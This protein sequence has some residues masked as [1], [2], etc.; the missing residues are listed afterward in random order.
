MIFLLKPRSVVSCKAVRDGVAWDQ[1]GRSRSSLVFHQM[2]S[3]TVIVINIIV[4]NIIVINIIVI[5]IIVSN[6]IVVNVIR[7]AL[8]H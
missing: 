5:N 2:H 1:S 3:Y 7:E 6:I 4:I 8:R